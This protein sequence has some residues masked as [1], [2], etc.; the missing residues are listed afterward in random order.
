[1][2][3]EDHS[4]VNRIRQGDSQSYA[5]LVDRYKDRVFSLV[6]GIVVSREV[7]EEV[8]QDV[9]I[10]AYSSINKFREESSFSTWLYR[11]AYNTAISETRKRKMPMVSLEEREHVTAR[12]SYEDDD[13]VEER[14]QQLKRAITE[15]NP[16]EQLIL[17]LYYREEKSVEDLSLC[18]NQTNANIK[19][20][21]FRLRNK[22][23]SLMEEMTRLAV[24]L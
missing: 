1:M 18:L 23:R 5:V 4:I 13:L 22:I 24:F 10:K 17:Q 8:A 21:L 3:N 19:I 2:S 20:K 12:I 16:E 14:H 7:A 15:L 11:I 6:L 9:F